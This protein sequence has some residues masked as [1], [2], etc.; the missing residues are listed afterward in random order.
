MRASS[1][2]A[3]C[4][5]GFIALGLS[6]CQGAAP[7]VA[8]GPD[9]EL[10][11]K[12]R[13]N[14]SQAS[15]Q[16]PGAA[17]AYTARSM[18]S[19]S[20]YRLVRAGSA[21]Q[22]ADLK[23]KLAADPAVEYVEKSQT[24][25]A[26]FTPND[27]Y[28]INGAQWNLNQINAPAAWDIDPGAGD[29]VIVA[30]LDTGV[31]Y[32][33][34]TD[35]KHSYKRMSDLSPATFVPGW[36]FIN[37]DSHPNDDQGH[38]THVAGVIA[39]ATNDG[40]GAAGLAYGAR[41]MPV[42]VLNEYGMGRDFDI[43]DGIYWAADRGAK[44]VNLSLGLDRPSSAIKEAIYY[45]RNVKGVTVVAAAGNSADPS[46]YPDYTG[47]LMYP[48]RYSSVI[49]VGATRY[50]R[51]RAAYSQYGRALDLVAPGGEMR[52]G[53]DRNGDHFPDGIVQETIKQNYWGFD[54]LV[55]PSRSAFCWAEGTS[56]SAPHVS[57]AA[58]M[59]IA[60]GTTSP[61]G[62]YRAL[63]RSAKDLGHQGRDRKYGY[64]LLN[65]AAALRYHP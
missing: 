40:Y 24:A 54:T 9:S 10:I 48:A 12:F 20:R 4:F 33:D 28:F 65:V 17:G 57:A 56:V 2:A 37:N 18:R 8:P 58:A 3:G 63:T 35:G 52:P 45:A 38:G 39:A 23:K 34:Y 32:E 60:G 13:A 43:A 62:V 16:S 36:D 42:K 49:S 51:K 29:G 30:V 41:V 11:V 46:E 53:L 64:G 44:V 50:G 47:G 14:A 1:K 26:L 7:A 59:V 55:D 5:L 27:P 61:A 6:F 31:A 19:D 22:V 21:A 15:L 25:R